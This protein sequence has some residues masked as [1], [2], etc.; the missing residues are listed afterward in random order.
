M[1]A[2]YPI[3]GSQHNLWAYTVFDSATMKPE[4][5][6]AAL[7]AE[8]V[9]GRWEL[10]IGGYFKKDDPLRGMLTA[11][12]SIRDVSLFGEATLARG[13][14]RTWVSEV[15]SSLSGF[16]TTTNRDDFNESFFFQGTAGFMYSNSE[17]NISVLGQ[18][19]YDGEGYSNTDRKARITEARDNETA[20]KGFL[21]MNPDLDVDAAFSGFLKGLILNSGR[22]YAC[23]IV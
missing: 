2:H 13:T 7:K 4:E 8:F 19:L 16:V 11:T 14:K 21:A 18:Y 6:A 9:L 20:I 12:G 3:P 10:G 23:G 15:S 5:T 17:A 1:R 22:H